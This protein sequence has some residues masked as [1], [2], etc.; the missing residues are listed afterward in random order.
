MMTKWGGA[1]NFEEYRVRPWV[2]KVSSGLMAP[3]SADKFDLRAG[4]VV[5]VAYLEGQS[6]EGVILGGLNHPAR[7]EKT[8]TGNIEYISMFNGIETQIRK[9]GSY[10]I[11]FKGLPINEAQLLIPPTGVPVPAPIFNPLISGSFYGFDKDGSYVVSDGKQFIKILKSPTAGAMVLVSG[12]NRIDLGGNIAQGTMG[13]KTD[14]LVMEGMKASLKASLSLNIEATQTSIKSTQVAIGNSQF[15]LFKG[16]DE[17]ID[18]IGSVVITSPV[19]TC[20]PIMASPQWA[21]KILPIQIK[22]KAVTGSLN[23][24]DAVKPTDEG[25]VKLASDVGS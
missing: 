7:K 6:R 22:I 16:L 21:S 20:T 13:F 10:K 11:T 12:K 25:D 2:G 24:A 3:A 4:D 15:E 5:L 23:S 17:L 8:K 18:A 14:N 9:D 19:G 1:F